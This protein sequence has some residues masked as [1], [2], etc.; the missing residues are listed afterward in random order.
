MTLPAEINYPFGSSFETISTSSFE[1]DDDDEDLNSSLTRCSST[2]SFS[3]GT[4]GATSPSSS[5]YSS[6]TTAPPVFTLY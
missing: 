1:R 4:S 6:P 2:K 3:E 5:S